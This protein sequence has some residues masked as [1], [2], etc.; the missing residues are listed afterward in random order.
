VNGQF[1]SRAAD[2]RSD[3]PLPANGVIR[4]ECTDLLLSA[5]RMSNVENHRHQ[6]NKL[7]KQRRLFLSERGHFFVRQFL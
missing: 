1:G 5:L 6:K 3:G 2:P 7:T 4:P